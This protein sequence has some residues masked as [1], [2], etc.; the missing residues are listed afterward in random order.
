MI[1]SLLA[2]VIAIIAVV[3]AEGLKDELARVRGELW[4]VQAAAEQSPPEA[5]GATASS[6]ANG[7]A[8][9]A[10][11]PEPR[12]PV[13]A[14]EP[15]AAAARTAIPGIPR[16]TAVPPAAAAATPTGPDGAERRERERRRPALD[17]AA[18]P[19]T[20]A[21]AP[22]A[23]DLETR[24][25]ATWALRLGLATLAIAVALFARSVVPALG[26]GAKVGLAYAG[27]L[28][29]F[30]VGRVFEGRQERFGR[31]V[32]AGAL[33]I[34]FF[35]SYASY[36]VPAMRALPL[37]PA[38]VWMAAGVVAVL[39][40][41]ER[42]GSEPTAGLA[43]FLGHVSAFVA[44]GV[45]DVYSLVVV[46]FLAAAAVLLLWRH[47]WLP[48]SLFALVAS[49]GSHLL[50]A[51]A[52]RAPAGPG[53]GIG[54]NL[55]FL[56]SYYAV[57]LGADLLWWRR[58]AAS[59]PSS[60]VMPALARA[61]GPANLVLL[62]SLTSF[63]YLASDGPVARLAW[64]FFGMA[65]LQLGLASAYHRLGNPDAGFY[66]ALAAVLVTL[67]FAAALDG[68]SLN[69]VL[70][71][72]AVALL[73][74]ANATRMR[75]FHLLAQGAL[76]ANFVHYWTQASV[77]PPDLAGYI[78][79]L[80]I[81]AAYLTQA[82]LEEAWYGGG[83]P[84]WRRAPRPAGAPGVVARM[85]DRAFGVVAPG[86]TYLH[87]FAA[88]ILIAHQSLRFLGAADA[89]MGMAVGVVA[90]AAAALALRSVPVLL[91]SAALQVAIALT[92]ADVAPGPWLA[93][94]LT[95]VG[96]AVPVV[97]TLSARSRGLRDRAWQATAALAQI[98]VLAALLLPL[99]FRG[100]ATDSSLYLAWMAVF[101]LGAAYIE[102]GRS[103]LGRS[104]TPVTPDFATLA[105]GGAG[106]T[107]LL[108]AAGALVMT[109]R[110]IGGVTAA[111]WTTG[112]AAA[113]MAAAAWR[114]QPAYTLAGL[115]L[116][117]LGDPYWLIGRGFGDEAI[118]SA[119][120][121]A[122]L[123]GVPLAAGLLHDRL[124]PRRMAGSEPGM[125]GPATYLPY[126]L[127]SVIA[128]V[129]CE[130]H[131]AEAWSSVAF[132]A[133]PAAL[134]LL[135]AGARERRGV[136][137]AVLLTMVALLDQI[138]YT[139][140]TTATGVP[141][142]LA[143]GLLLATAALLLER[144]LAAG[145]SDLGE[146]DSGRPVRLGLLL[147]ATAL[148]LATVH[149][150]WWLGG[151]RTTI[152]WSLVGGLLM[153]AGFAARSADY[154]RI[155]LGVLG[156]AVVRVFALD[157]RGLTDTAKTLAFLALGL[158]LVAVAWLYSRFGRRLREWL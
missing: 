115:T 158:S 104:G 105:R 135:T 85:F 111:V 147:T 55:L 2:L 110:L 87:A 39:L 154:R 97:V 157:T 53:Y 80:A 71:V 96:I 134:L 92:T 155:A 132:A 100:S 131:V 144:A 90:L 139:T 81:A 91:A 130:T 150:S 8:A 16:P 20:A 31:P 62:V 13:R 75:V 28:A 69:L 40:L 6:P 14:P 25:G 51:V 83:E 33:A 123:A 50:W 10:E 109:E 12:P 61:L 58:R 149:G 23:L 121:T 156:I 56:A 118:D 43:I 27:A 120:M 153:G 133:V 36:F 60:S 82:V 79:G 136:A 72:E 142:L 143:P 95:A 137:V 59:T 74:A 57:F 76:A 89:L 152:G 86:L 34:G 73:V 15:A 4:A 77:T 151:P 128:L 141:D 124:G 47:D 107:A 70:A 140:T 64:V 145:A 5:G 127:G 103:S 114:R 19:A 116:L 22:R 125:A 68:L 84:A 42:W 44:G 24:V 94:A 46:L 98:A 63:L 52:D 99:A 119:W 122:V 38:L 21:G 129:W 117:L 146:A 66:P 102:V 138:I 67:G 49:Y 1:L 93:L 26:P 101:A 18:R 3:K 9:G 126:L 78:G 113:L 148:A 29:L 37:I 54:V 48:L 106:L 11:V 45:T 35:I 88:A 7:L 30:G 41:A 17:G 32:M 112:W 108:I 65:A